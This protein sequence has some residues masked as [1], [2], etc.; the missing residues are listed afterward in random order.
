[1]DLIINDSTPAEI[2]SPHECGR[3]LDLSGR[4][5]GYAYGGVAEPFPD[6]LLIP[7]SEWQARIQ[8]REERKTT[9]YAQI[10]TAKLPAKDQQRLNYCWCFGPT[11]C[12]EIVRLLQNE[13]M[14]SLSPASVGGPITGFRNVGGYGPTALE[15]IV[16]NGICPSSAW[17]DT[18]LD[19]RYYTP[20]NR[21]LASEYRVTEWWELEPG[22]LDQLVSCLL[23]GIPVAGGFDW[24]SHEVA[25]IDPVWR[26]GQVCVRIRNQWQGWGDDNFAVLQGPRMIPDDAVCPRVATA[27]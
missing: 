15:F 13:P 5:R 23:L 21:K 6:T 7:Q 11:Q 27:V 2:H 26:D 1:M 20:A 17:P 24:W 19:S 16:K 18:A 10:T 14:V 4:P 22:N 25:M 12:V 8:E 3:G 9:L